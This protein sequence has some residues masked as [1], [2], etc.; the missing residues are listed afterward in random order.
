MTEQMRAARYHRYGPPEVL[1]V[2]HVPM[3]APGRREVLVRVRATSVNPSEAL[4][5]AGKMRLL[6]GF[7]FPKGTGQ[8]FAGEVEAV[9]P[10]AD[11]ALLGR[12]VWGTRL[13]LGAAAAAEYLR[14]PARLVA[15][16]PAGL[17][18]PDAAALPT[19]GLTALMA[20]RAARV[21][22]GS[23]VLVVGA[24]GGV[25]SATVQLA[26]AAGAEVTTVSSP[27]N[28]DFCTELGAHKAYA[29]TEPHA[30]GTVTFDAVIDLHGKGLPPY[31]RRVRRGGRMLSLS[32]RA[33]V[34]ALGT[35]LRPGP[36]V[37]LAQL[38]PTTDDLDRLA[39]H[40]AAGELRAVVDHV[41]PLADIAAAHRDQETGHSRGKRVIHVAD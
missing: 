23:A 30:L 11:T 32:P 39:G 22:S 19:V 24:S 28:T 21:R 18:P 4:V 1:Q 13:G 33:M 38:K 37:R 17:T 26:R 14:V 2:E 9:G 31:R 12:Q 27:V 40:I 8:D 20:L 7:R 15:A 35:A 16:T 3:P 6:S 34:Y 5:R 10:G 36:L 29:Y 25:G 41:Y